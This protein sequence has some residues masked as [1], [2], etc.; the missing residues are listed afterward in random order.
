MAATV[1]VGSNKCVRYN[2]NTGSNVR[3]IIYYLRVTYCSN[4][5]PLY[6]AYGDANQL[7]TTGI[8]A[9]LAYPGGDYDED[10]GGW[11]RER[12][13]E[14]GG[15]YSGDPGQGNNFYNRGTTNVGIEE[16]EGGG[17]TGTG[18]LV[19]GYVSE[20]DMVYTFQPG[21]N[22]YPFISNN[23][24]DSGNPYSLGDEIYVDGGSGATTGPLFVVSAMGGTEAI[25]RRVSFSDHTINSE[26]APALTIEIGANLASFG[27]RS[28]GEG[29][30]GAGSALALQNAASIN[31]ENYNS[32]VPGSE[33]VGRTL[34]YSLPTEI[35]LADGDGFELYKVGIGSTHIE[36]FNFVAIPEGG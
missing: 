15:E 30:N 24:A 34:G 21:N 23:G 14:S 5:H 11:D 35:F 20:D 12:A 25:R 1:H 9:E 26:N 8:P 3:I 33:I 29:S 19:T 18:M 10:E 2:N 4:T 36:S 31:L 13:G 17:G 27:G 7:I 28:V 16:G 32:T 6:F 22:G